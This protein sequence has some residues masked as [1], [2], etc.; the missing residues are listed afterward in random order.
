[1]AWRGSGAGLV[2]SL[3]TLA[4]TRYFTAN[5]S[6]SDWTG[7]KKPLSG[8]A[9]SQ[10]SAP[11]FGAGRTPHEAVVASAKTFDLERLPGFDPVLPPEVGGQDDLAFR[12]N[13]R[14]HML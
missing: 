7:T 12:G 6:T 11:A 8:Q 14:L 3:S 10:S 5:R 2:G 1:M 4:S 9:R 13:R